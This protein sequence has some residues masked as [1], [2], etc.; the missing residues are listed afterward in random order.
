MPINRGTAEHNPYNLKIVS[1]AEADH[2]DFYTLSRA[3]VTHIVNGVAEFTPL[4]QW[5]Q[6]YQLFGKVIQIPLFQK[7]KMWKSYFV[8]RK[9]VRSSRMQSSENVLG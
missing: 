5:E 8:W 3:G 2:D 7:Y 6:E 4:D 1:H 9:N